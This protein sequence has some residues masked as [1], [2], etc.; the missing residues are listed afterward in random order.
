M[1]FRLLSSLALLSLASFAH[2][3]TVWL[4]NGDRLT[5]TIKLLDSK[6]LLLQTE[7]GGNIPLS[8]DK[9]KTL[10]RDKPVIVQ[11]GKYEP[12]FPVESL[13]PADDGQ[14]VVSTADGQQTVPLA[15]ITQIVPPRPF[16]RDFA[17][18]GNIDAGLDYISSSQDSEKYDID[19]KTQARHGMWRHNANGSYD[20]YKTD[21][22]VSTSKYGLQ[23]ALD[24]FFDEK[25]F[26]Q[27]GAEYKRDWIQD[28]A[29]QRT[30]GTGPGYQF[31]DNELGAFS[32][33]G[34]LNHNRYEYSDG[35]SDQFL[36][37]SVKWD[38]NRYLYGQTIQFF[39]TGELG[40]PLDNTANLTFDGDVGLRYKVTNWASLN[41]KASKELTSGAE[42]N[43][44]QTEYT[45]G[46]GV[47]W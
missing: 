42:G 12:D 40:R 26:W 37:A 22:V 47:S 32:L 38:Y 15:S 44:N 31:W 34:L 46:V 24:R 19:F 29:K 28:L 11:R 27:G 23:Y 21:D 39:T 16:L 10:Q 3:D 36:S 4:K 20:R 8:W 25:F 43:V 41:L 1:R 9:I 18:K 17:W 5:G 2:A 6:K 14:V 30:L 45:A 13:K 7:Y 35:G 33:T